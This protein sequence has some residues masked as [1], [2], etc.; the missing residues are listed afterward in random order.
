[1]TALACFRLTSAEF[2]LV[3]VD[4]HV[5]LDLDPKFRIGQTEP[6]SFR[7]PKHARITLA[8]RLE[9]F[10]L[11]RV[12]GDERGGVGIVEE[13]EID[14]A[15]EGRRGE[16]RVREMFFE[17]RIEQAVATFRRRDKARTS[18]T[19]QHH[20]PRFGLPSIPT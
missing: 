6:V 7:R 19:S 8:T 18:P 20:C 9:R 11:G 4:S 3:A 1:M 15:G 16:R 10:D 12:R 17:A 13:A 5:L 2:A 14:Q